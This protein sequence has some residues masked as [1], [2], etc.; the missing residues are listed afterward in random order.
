MV[1]ITQRIDSSTSSSG[2]RPFD[3]RRDLN[4]VAD[5]VEQCFADTLDPDGQHY[6]GQMR[7]AAGNPAYLRLPVPQQNESPSP[8]RA[9]F[10]KRQA[11]SWA[12]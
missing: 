4:Q 12:T 2:L 9:T 11:G 8:S 6:L 5:L 10:G 7:A 3:V 1:A